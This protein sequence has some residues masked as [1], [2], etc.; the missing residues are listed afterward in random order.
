MSPK[1]NRYLVLV[2][3]TLLLMVSWLNLLSL[4][5]SSAE[6]QLDFDTERLFIE[7]K[8]PLSWN[9]RFSTWATT[10]HPL[11]VIVQQA[12][13]INFDLIG[14]RYP[15]SWKIALIISAACLLISLCVWMHLARKRKY[16]ITAYLIP[17]IVLPLAPALQY[18]FK[19][20]EEDAIGLSIFSF[21]LL[22]LYVAAEKQKT[23]GFVLYAIGAVAALSWHLQYGI[24]IIFG[25]SIFS[26]FLFFRSRTQSKK[27]SLKFIGIN[28]VIIIS[29]ILLHLVKSLK[30]LPYQEKY[31]SLQTALKENSSLDKYVHDFTIS[32]QKA[33]T[34][35]SLESVF[36]PIFFL[37]WVST[38]CLTILIFSSNR[39]T[40][41][42]SAVASAFLVTALWPFFYE[43]DSLERWT[44]FTLTGL[45]LF[46]LLIV[47][48]KGPEV[49]SPKLSDQFSI[50]N[51]TG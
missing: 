20:Q 50:F 41:G 43:H 19:T 45:L 12:W 35:N 44:S 15:T 33:L 18:I 8:L 32:I 24:A 5:T 38:I 37:I 27:H 2:S 36:T 1:I 31:T 49:I 48:R 10:P 9:E 14:L 40:P 26:T 17:L 6:D 13:L 47:G 46:P 34:G 29:F 4:F 42:I 21:S 3:S 39:Y 16:P 11:G 28:S 25:S 22:A 7:S 51:H 23:S 30:Y